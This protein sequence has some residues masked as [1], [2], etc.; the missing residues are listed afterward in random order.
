MLFLHLFVRW[1][2]VGLGGGMHAGEK[3]GSLDG[4]GG[5]SEQTSE[6]CASD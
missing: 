5:A 2:L 3:V 1:R 4:C 6:R